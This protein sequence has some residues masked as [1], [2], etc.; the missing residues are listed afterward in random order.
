MVAVGLMHLF[1]MATSYKGVHGVF[2]L[3]EGDLKPKN[4]KL[5]LKTPKYGSDE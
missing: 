1:N 4:L 3:D 5:Q 2:I